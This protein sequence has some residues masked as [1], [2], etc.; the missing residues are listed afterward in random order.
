MHLSGVEMFMASA[1]LG[2]LVTHGWNR[3]FSEAT[4][5]VSRTDGREYIV[6][7]ARDKQEAAERLAQLNA[8]ILKFIASLEAAFPDDVRVKRLKRRYNP[9]NVSEGS[10]KSGYTSYSVNKGERIVVCMRQDDDAFVDTNDLLYVVIHELA[11]L[12]TDEVGHTDEFWANFRF[13]LEHA[14]SSKVYV[15]KDYG[16][17]PVS[18]CGMKISS[19]IL[20]H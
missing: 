1:V 20:K 17:K 9:D 18:Y 19:S 8:V 14:V 5:V 3:I 6:T 11:H 2:T 4:T 7:D 10:S 16:N 13:L 15:Y 12:A